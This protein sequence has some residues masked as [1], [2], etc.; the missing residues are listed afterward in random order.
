[1]S[2]RDIRRPRQES[3]RILAALDHLKQVGNQKISDIVAAVEAEDGDL[4]E[5]AEH[6]RQLGNAL[7]EIAELLDVSYDPSKSIKEQIEDG[8]RL[9]QIDSPEDAL[10]ILREQL[11]K[12]KAVFVGGKKLADFLGKSDYVTEYIDR[13][14][15][16]IPELAS[17]MGIEEP[18]SVPA[19]DIPPPKTRRS[20][21]GTTI[22]G[23]AAIAGVVSGTKNP[24]KAATH[25]SREDSL[26][27]MNDYLEIMR[28]DFHEERV[29]EL[30]VAINSASLSA[31]QKKSLATAINET[32]GLSGENRIPETARFTRRLGSHVTQTILEKYKDT[33]HDDKLSPLLNDLSS[34]LTDGDL[35]QLV[36]PERWMPQKMQFD[37]LWIPENLRN[38]GYPN[39]KVYWED[40]LG[41][42]KGGLS[43]RGQLPA[44]E[45][46]EMTRYAAVLKSAVDAGAGVIVSCIAE[47]YPK[48][49]HERWIE[50]DQGSRVDLLTYATSHYKPTA[51]STLDENALLQD[52][53]HIKSHQ[54]AGP[55]R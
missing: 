20:F 27:R 2:L 55:E 43:T 37:D 15:A 35:K 10:N 22:A 6:G 46:G 7:I 30:L 33:P 29:I 23:S 13:L 42:G 19:S 17:L 14:D 54:P 3:L 40:T 41:K 31:E 34:K 38:E 50:T 8:E 32:L 53:R 24:Q 44:T 4:Y 11:A 25:Q 48:F 28:N 49:L 39:A 12:R 36:N 47:A 45:R 18:A 9:P 16:V 5:P 51:V 21:I 1:M 52:L 26:R